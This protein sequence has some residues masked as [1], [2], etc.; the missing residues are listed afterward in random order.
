M[1]VSKQQKG[2]Q[3]P[4][5]KRV[6]KKGHMSISIYVHTSRQPPGTHIII[7]TCLSIYLYPHEP[8]VPPQ[9]RIAQPFICLYT[10]EPSAP[11]QARTVRPWSRTPRRGWPPSPPA[12]CGRGRTPVVTTSG[13]GGGWDE[14]HGGVDRMGDRLGIHPTEGGTPGDSDPHPHAPPTHARTRHPSTPHPIHTPHA[15]GTQPP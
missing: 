4:S 5:P 6:P 7:R 1:G 13:G 11:R 14:R 9:A 15:P 10:H 12:G 3:R 8:P 2:L